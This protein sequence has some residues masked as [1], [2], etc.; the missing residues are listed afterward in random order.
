MLLLARALILYIVFNLSFV[1][2]KEIFVI[3]I[4]PE[5]TVQSKSTVGSD[6]SVLEEKEINNSNN[7]FIGDIFEGFHE[8]S[9]KSNLNII[10]NKTN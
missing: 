2:A 3:V 1:I 8:L 9:S 6:I 5:K 10:K 7:F 4:A